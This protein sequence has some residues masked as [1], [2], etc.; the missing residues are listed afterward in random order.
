MPARDRPPAL[1]VWMH[2]Q[3]VAELTD[4][5]G[6]RCRHLPEAIDRFGLN[7]ALLSCSLPT[8]PRPVDAT[9]FFD[10][11]LPEGQLRAALA[12]RAGVLATDTFGL[13]ARYGRDVAGALVIAPPDVEPGAGGAVL[14]LDDDELAAEV[15]ALP[16]RP[17]GIHD[18]SELSLAG[19]QDKM[20][21]VDLGDGHWG[22]PTGGAPSTHIL[23]LDHRVHRG[24][25]DAEAD[26]LT[27]ARAAGLTT[28]EAQV[29]TVGDLRCL[30]VSRF[31]RVIEQSGAVVRLHQEDACQALGRPPT[32]KYELRQGGGGP[33]LEEVARLLDLHAPGNQDEQ[34]DRLA[35][36]AAFTAMIGNVDAHGK[37]LALLHDGPGQVGLAPLYDQVPT[38]LWPALVSDAAM[39]I[40]GVV[41]LA[42]V[43][44]DA[45]EREARRWRHSPARASAAASRTA[46]A[47][48]GAIDAGAIDPGGALAAVVR[49][50][51]PK[52]L[53]ES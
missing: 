43:G 29:R 2:G 22:R 37:N 21:L 35:S 23:K 16:E 34:L 33:E 3:P 48:L 9:A 20:L 17:L 51:A 6:I 52:L 40:G 1:V 19:L 46:E 11:V 50:R 8:G 25:V 18:D 39:S 44:S 41:S 27:L 47:V 10:G 7:V 42:A 31:D 45:I 4:R 38:V 32:Q 49:A 15:Q 14:P 5:R 26:A 36:V 12:A 53:P 28:V 30:I 24:V 13:L